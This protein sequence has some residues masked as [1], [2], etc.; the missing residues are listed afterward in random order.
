[1]PSLGIP[2]RRH[3][4]GRGGHAGP[5]A[6]LRRE[7]RERLAL[8]ENRIPKLHNRGIT[9]DDFKSVLTC[10]AG[11]RDEHA[12]VAAF[13]STDF[14][15]LQISHAS[16]AHRGDRSAGNAVI[17]ELLHA[18]PLHGDSGVIV[19]RVGEFQF[20]AELRGLRLQ[21]RHVRLDARGVDDEQE[22]LRAES[23]VAALRT[24]LSHTHNRISL[25][26]TCIDY[27]GRNPATVTI[28]GDISIADELPLQPRRNLATASVRV[29]TWSFS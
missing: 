5:P 8:R 1:M 19:R 9:A 12:A 29:R 28:T 3:G 25:R 13:E 18:R 7:G 23:P 4:H 17:N 26:T 10:V 14:V 6:R 27:Q 2:R 24:T 22:F 16:H 11:A 21:P 20:A 15:L